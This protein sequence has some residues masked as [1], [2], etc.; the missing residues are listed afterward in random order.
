MTI[1]RLLPVFLVLL[2]SGLVAAHAHA[3]PHLAN[4]AQTPHLHVHDLLS[5]IV[6]VPADEGDHD[7]GDHDADA[8][9]L[10]DV[11][12]S[13]AP[14]P[15]VDAVTFD[16]VPAALRPAFA[17]SVEPLFPV[18]LPPATAGPHRPR[19]LTFCTLTI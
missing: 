14:P 8:V 13:A 17:G 12:V 18:G 9:D 7:E 3:H 19:Y 15:A 2:Q 1:R 6:P 11:T 16:S 10:S 5:L 4:H